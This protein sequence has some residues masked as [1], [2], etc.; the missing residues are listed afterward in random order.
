[1][2]LDDTRFVTKSN[3]I[4]SHEVKQYLFKI[5]KIRREEALCHTIRIELML[6]FGLFLS[7]PQLTVA[8]KLYCRIKEAVG[9]C[10]LQD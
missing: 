6:K 1:M 9:L 7:G 2:G 5:S 8:F 4:R 10:H 3:L